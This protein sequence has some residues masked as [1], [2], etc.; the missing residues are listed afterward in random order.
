MS[1]VIATSPSDRG[2]PFDN[3]RTANSCLARRDSRGDLRPRGH[4]QTF[5]VACRLYNGWA[6]SELE[7]LR[8]LERYN[9]KCEPPWRLAELKHKA[10]SAVKAR[11]KKCRGHM[12]G[13]EDPQTHPAP[14]RLPPKDTRLPAEGFASGRTPGTPFSTPSPISK[15]KDLCFMCETRK[16]GVASVPKKRAQAW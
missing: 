3:A 9:E 2:T 13:E 10:A 15:N 7:V 1:A 14:I 6:L 5:C 11:H 4:N 8:W 12:L 16:K